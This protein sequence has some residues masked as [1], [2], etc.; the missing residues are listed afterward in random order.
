MTP[1]RVK[2]QCANPQP[3]LAGPCGWT[4]LRAGRTITTWSSTLG[5]MRTF[6]EPPTRKPCPRCGGPVKEV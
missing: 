6:R 2:V 3:T 1:D 4:G 5:G